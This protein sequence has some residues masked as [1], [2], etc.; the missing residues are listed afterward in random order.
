MNSGRLVSVAI[1]A[2]AATAAQA[3]TSVTV[4]GVA[5]GDFR[6]DHT[7]VGTLKGIGS[8]GYLASRW[9]IRGSEDLGSGLKANFVFEQGFDLSDNSANQGNVTPATP[10]TNVSSTGGRLFSRLATVGMSSD[11]LGN[12][13]VGRDLKSIFVAALTADAFKGSYVGTGANVGIPARLNSRYDNGVYYDSPTVGGLRLTANIALGESTTDTVPGTPKNAGNKF[14]SGIYYTRGPLYLTYAYSN[15]K[16]GATSP[17]ISNSVNHTR[18]NVAGA[19]YDFGIFKIHGLAFSG[20]DSL[21]FNVRSGH[22]GTSVPFG[23]WTFIA[24]YGHVNDMGASNP[25]A[26]KVKTNYDANFY[27][28][29]AQYSFSKRTLVYASGAAWKVANRFGGAYGIVDANSPSIGLLTTSNIFG[30][31]PWS[32]QIG[33]DH[34]F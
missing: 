10:T 19:V 5:D 12:L 3:Q 8:G 23:A 29:T 26:P 28:A 34:L 17:L 6:V 13:R 1:C 31:N 14:G 20:K 30:V 16:V 22:I 11:L 15:D 33:I 7:N 18:V 21:G 4:Y 25:A 27:G 9:G 32:A 2:L 24:G